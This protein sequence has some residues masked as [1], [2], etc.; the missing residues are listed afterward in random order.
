M[1]ST[2]FRC[3]AR[4]IVRNAPRA[5]LSCLP[6]GE[7][8]FDIARDAMGEWLQARRS[9]VERRAELEQL[10]NTT[11][12]AARQQAETVAAE[13]ARSAPE[14]AALAGYLERLPGV[15]RRS[16]SRPDDMT[17]RTVPAT[18]PLEC[19]EHLVPFLPPRPPRFRPGDRLSG[20]KAQQWE[21]IEL[22]GNGGFGEVWRARTLHSANGDEV[23]V[24]FCLDTAAVATLR[25]EAALLQRVMAHGSSSGL[26]VLRDVYLLADPPFLVYDY[27][28]GGDLTRL[29]S[30]WHPAG[31][32]PPRL[33]EE[34]A[35][36]CHYLAHTL[37]SAHE[38][39]RPVVHRD[40]KPSNILLQPTAPGRVKPRIAD[41]GI[42]GIAARH[43]LIRAA[44][45]SQKEALTTSL[46]GAHTPLY[47][48]P[49]QI[50]GQS[51]DPRDDVYALGVILYQVLTGDTTTGPPTDWRDEL[52]DRSV[53]AP[54]VNVVGRC[55]ATDPGR[56][57]ST[58]AALA[59]LLSPLLPAARR[60]VW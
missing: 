57:P 59:E 3:L 26:V 16:L 52:D 19:P 40:L 28:P 55:L 51:P 23:A 12:A 31:Y 13:V 49:Q 30:G 35:R 11:P 1:S 22:V 41:F 15:V 53:P 29:I 6:F 47:A 25:T 50:E 33:N 32:R 5:L 42:G 24:K 48:S 37:R 56:R 38:L 58:A 60:A 4:A 20:E 14:R 21:L 36:L 39:D 46:R 34:A 27:I 43:A 2:L 7:A 10:A 9:A 17:G 18:L 44:T 8:L 54:L 45:T